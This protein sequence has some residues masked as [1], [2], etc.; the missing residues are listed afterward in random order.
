MIMRDNLNERLWQ[1]PSVNSNG[2]KESRLDLLMKLHLTSKTDKLIHEDFLETIWDSCVLKEL[3]TRQYVMYSN[4][5]YALELTII[6]VFCP[7]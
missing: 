2:D 3:V 4:Q 6:N 1:T 7:T 5:N